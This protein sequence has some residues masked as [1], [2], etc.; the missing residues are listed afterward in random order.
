MYKLLACDMDGTLIGRDFILNKLDIDALQAAGKSGIHLVLCSGRSYESLKFFAQEIGMISPGNFLIGFNGCTVYDLGA[1]KVL[2]EEGLGMDAAIAALAAHKDSDIFAEPVVY[3]NSQDVLI[4]GDG[5]WSREY[6]KTSRVNAI[7]CKDQISALGEMGGGVSKIIFIGEYKN[8]QKLAAILEM[9]LGDSAIVV[10]SAEYLL[11]V[12]TSRTS[13]GA[14]LGW[15]C[16]YLSIDLTQ[17]IAIGDNFNDITM[18]NSA[19]LG[20]AVANAVDDVKKI[21]D[22]VTTADCQNGAVAEVIGKFIL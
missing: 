19:G 22:Y 11:E 20:V 2:R 9:R 6:M 10:F 7:V 3:K 13:K 5:E 18:L 12:M 17:T 14:A 16:Q 21:A 1:D 4:L 8:L 15:L